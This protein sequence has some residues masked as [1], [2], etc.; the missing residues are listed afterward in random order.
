MSAQQQPAAR[1][2]FLAALSPSDFELARSHL[3]PFELR[4]GDCLHYLGEP[5]EN[6]VFPHSGVVLMTVPLREGAGA[7]MRLAGREAIIGGF[8]GIGSGPASCDAEVF[9][10]G[11][12]SRMSAL[13]FRH[14]LEQS[15]AIR[16]QASRLDSAALAQAQQTALCNA[17]HPVES[18]ICRWLLELDDRIGSARIPLTQAALAQMLGVRRTT[19]TLLA[20]RLEAAGVIG[21]GRGAMLIVNRSELEHRSCECYAQLNTYMR[22]L[23]A[24]PS[25]EATAGAVPS[26]Q[27]SRIAG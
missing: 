22:R 6:V 18:R 11:H 9:A 7:G 19:V 20:G 3:V 27:P 5:I 25:S 14:L 21:C 26:G 1:N 16:R 15:P 23:F 10:E 12:A 8:A 13:A 2:S 17:V 24:P 4:T